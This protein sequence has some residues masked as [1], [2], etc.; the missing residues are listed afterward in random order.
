MR[1]IPPELVRQ[2]N[3]TDERSG[4]EYRLGAIKHQI[5][6]YF[7]AMSN[8]GFTVELMREHMVGEEMIGKHSMLASYHGQPVLMTMRGHANIEQATRS[9]QRGPRGR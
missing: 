3:F 4:V 5:S 6:D 1:P 7:T 9:G 2:A 8:A